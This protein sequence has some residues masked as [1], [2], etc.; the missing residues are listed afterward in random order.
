MKIW[1][2][3][4][5]TILRMTIAISI[6]IALLAILQWQTHLVTKTAK[7]YLDHALK[8]KATISYSNISGT[9]INNIEIKNL[10]IISKSGLTV[11]V[12]YLRLSY[13][14][15][16]LLKNKVE[17]SRAIIDRLQ[18][19]LPAEKSSQTETPF[20]ADSLL[21]YLQKHYLPKQLLGNLPSFDL[22]NFHLTT[23]FFQ[24]KNRPLT[25]TNI[26]LDL[27]H[28]R[29]E[30]N[31][32]FLMLTDMSGYW[33]EQNL[34][35]ASLSFVLKGDPSGITLDQGE[36]RS[37]KS[38]VS[39]NILLDPTSGFNINF[40]RFH[41][42]VNEF[43]PNDKNF[44]VKNGIVKGRLSLSGMPVHFGVQG[45][46]Q[47]RFDQRTIRKFEFDMR[48]NRGEVFLNRLVVQ[49]NIGIINAQGY[50][51]RQRRIIGSLRFAAINL[52][53]IM[54]SLPVSRLNGALQ[55]NA[56][57]LRLR[58]L[59]GFGSLK[60]YN[61]L[62]DTIA[63]DSIRLK[64]T[65]SN[66]FL[67]FIR[68]SFIQIDDSSRFYLTGTMAPNQRIDFS[69]LTFDNRL[70]HLLR[71][72]GGRNIYGK[73]DGRIH[74]YG[75]LANPN[76]SGNLTLPRLR[77]NGIRL[78]S[79]KF[80]IFIEGLAKERRGDGKFKIA[81]GQIGNFPV[82]QVS[83]QLHSEENRVQIRDL[84]FIS[85]KNYFKTSI[86]VL[87]S[88]DSMSVKAF[89]FQIQYEN[90]WI[91]AQDT[92]L[93]TLNADEAQLEAWSF[94]GPD[95]ST[96]NID[97]FYDFK[98]GDLQTFITLKKVQ[99]TPFEHVFKTNLGLSGILNGYAEILTPF[100]DPN[101]EVDLQLRQLKIHKV[102]L[103]DLTSR[104][105]YAHDQ[106]SIDSL[107]LKYRKSLIQAQGALNLHM[108]QSGL[109]FIEHTQARFTLN[110]NR[111]NIHS[112][113]KLFKDLH[114]LQGYSSGKLEIN[115]QVNDPVI[116]AD[117]RL[118]RFAVNRFKGDSLR[119]SARYEKDRFWLDHFSV[120]L[121]SSHIK[122]KGWQ[123]YHLAL[124]GS[125]DNILD[126]PFEL[127]LFSRDNQLLF[128]GNLNDVVESIQGPYLID[129]KLGG[130]PAKPSVLDGTIRLENGAILLSMIRDPIKKVYF[131]G[132]IKN[133]VLNIEQCS[134]QS[135]E[136][137]DFWQKAWAFVT[138][139]LPWGKPK[140][141]EGTMVVNGAID[142]SDLSRPFVDL[143]VKLN[144]FY[145]DYF[146]QNIS[147]V[148]S[149]DNLTIQ[150]RDT[151]LVQGDLY[152][153]KGVFEVDLN[154]IARNVYLSEGVST[155]E[156]PYIALNLHLQIPGNFV[157]TS[158]PLDLKNNFKLNF[159]GDLQVTMQPPSTEPRI[160]GHL[161]ATDGKYASWNQNFVVETATIDFK[162]NPTINP[163]INFKAFKILGNKTFELSM[164]GDLNNLHQEIRV[165]E[166]GQELNLS[167][168]DKIALLTL[169]ADISTLQSNADSTLRNV[170][171]NIATTSILTA[172]ER[173]AE[174]FTGLD[175]VE[176][177]SNKSLIDLNR[178][179][180][181]NGLSDASI[182]FG[183]YLTSD[184]YVEYR[185][186]FGSSIPA[187]RLSWDAGNRIGL[188]YRINRYWS[189]DSY[190][191]KTE[192]GNT[193]IKF[194]L[195][196]EYSF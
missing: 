96:L 38:T 54:P 93:V 87:W 119:L 161:E 178:L 23:S 73:F 53:K 29:V 162:N 142:F 186:Q 187:P 181:N 77:Y 136:E 25:F 189:L 40:N 69:L 150:G 72:L 97:G 152:I 172:V 42:D 118:N 144:Q 12:A 80:N 176:I 168:L 113:A 50:W 94:I 17:I 143:S 58:H 65:A 126:E 131:K 34:Q 11:S 184:L 56:S 28:L 104:W 62:L 151:I 157:V 24:V 35:L 41:V 175:K 48:Y 64:M 106:L 101:F 122:A 79:L 170:G 98:L 179:R 159:M 90:Y 117:I 145:A 1:R 75:P 125:Q 21:A 26:R 2:I 52:N 149:S 14:L 105:R 32:I 78:D 33:Q 140:I 51:N 9:L 108:A 193:R 124:S 67:K 10:K 196:W 130:T 68:P 30:P 66:G 156:P 95:S 194:G 84:Q 63:I 133:S 83:F 188:Q 112:Y 146:I 36:L 22:K 191:E 171:E 13:R 49:S 82:D 148:V 129:L 47:A 154:Q 115:G 173:G 120:L 114:R 89:P 61:S 59:S 60:L 46:I 8:G 177:S 4:K 182:A 6:I 7:A 81:S 16:P 74:L 55:V 39:F 180:L 134:A 111:L 192:R 135:R 37:A 103:G 138:S 141:K 132:K 166:N 3:F 5:K 160:Q 137:K 116:R 71:D 147:A 153:P 164:N 165:L 20:S 127:H 18:V 88:L 92:L 57:N 185:T 110:W 99:I 123:K 121:D 155:P 43:I 128:L 76:F 190:Y 139:F 163:D 109:N 100:T 102:P 70:N 107:I 91:K 19:E 31:A 169:G 167:Y 158:S 85:Q 174:H 183:K 86:A 195:K 27:A 44:F 45:Q 15:W